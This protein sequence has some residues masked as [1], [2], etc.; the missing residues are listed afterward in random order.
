M[1]KLGGGARRAESVGM[2]DKRGGAARCRNCRGGF[3]GRGG[4]ELAGPA[5]AADPTANGASGQKEGAL[6]ASDAA[7]SVACD[8]TASDKPDSDRVRSTVL[9]VSSAVR[10]PH[11]EPA[12]RGVNATAREFT[13]FEP[14]RDLGCSEGCSA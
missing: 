7:I 3:G 2:S 11:G 9:A 14:A 10:A 6:E 4:G 5:G 13:D 1:S 8:R 12:K